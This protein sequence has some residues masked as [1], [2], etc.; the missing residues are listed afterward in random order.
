MKIRH[1]VI[2]E[3]LHNLS[4]SEWKLFLYIVK[5]ENQETGIVEG[6][7]YRD[8]MKH[9]GMCR[10]SFY[11][12][13]RGLEEK[14]VIS[15]HK[16]SEIDYD[17]L[18]LGNACGTEQARSEGYVSLNRK[19]FH[20]RAFRKLKPQELYLLFSFLKC[21]HEN[22]GSMNIGV[23]RFYKQFSELLKVTVKTLRGYLHS[24][25]LFFSVCIKDGKYYITYMHSKFKKL[26]PYDKEWQSER[27]YYLEGLVKKECHRRRITYSREALKDV[28][29]LP[30]Q[31]QDYG[32]KEELFRIL[33]ACMEES[34]KGKRAAERTLQ[35][36]YIHRLVRMK[37]E[38]P[39]NA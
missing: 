23:R 29:Y 20:S 17:V 13:L 11:N 21:T 22:S 1:T 27:S 37:L 4:P 5:A 7:Y 38:L 30:V 14:Q 18:I 24:L 16:N 19:A 2:T 10:Q 15:M 3:K 32:G 33:A 8:V 39:V 9:T 34:V 26:T 25:R 36:E 6:V 28:A 12:A 31:Y 35:N